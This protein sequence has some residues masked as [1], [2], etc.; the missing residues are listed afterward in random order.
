MGFSFRL[1]VTGRKISFVVR[2]M[3]GMIIAHY[4]IVVILK[5]GD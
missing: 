2:C 5:V 1:G 4:N 3:P